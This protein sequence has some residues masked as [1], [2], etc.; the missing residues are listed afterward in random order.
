[1]VTKKNFDQHREWWPIFFNCHERLTYGIYF[2]S[3]PLQKHMTCPPFFMVTKSFGCYRDGW[4]KNPR[5]WRLFAHISMI[6]FFLFSHL[7]MIK[8]FRSPHRV[9]INPTKDDHKVCHHGATQGWRG[10]SKIPHVHL[11]KW[12]LMR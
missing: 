11:D 10:A 7:T 5:H 9:V 2:E 12:N 3:P 1:M 8:K 4:L 6:K